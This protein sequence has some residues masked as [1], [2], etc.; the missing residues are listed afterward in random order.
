MP[1]ELAGEVRLTE[2]QRLGIIVLLYKG[3]DKPVDDVASYR[4]ITLLNTDVKL[5]ARVLV[6]SIFSYGR[7]GPLV[8]A[9]RL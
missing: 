1:P 4:P 2:S 7:G 5:L 3:G 9:A 8:T 6:N